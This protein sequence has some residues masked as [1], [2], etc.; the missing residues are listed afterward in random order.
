MSRRRHGKSL[1]L[2]LRDDWRELQP[3]IADFW[4]QVQQKVAPRHAPGRL[5]QW[6]GLL[7]RNHADA[8]AL[9][10]RVREARTAAEIDAAL[11]A[12]PAA[13]R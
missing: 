2:N 10:R 12:T 8:E 13:A 5:K 6:L 9:W 1:F 4:S 3:L 7:R 11:A